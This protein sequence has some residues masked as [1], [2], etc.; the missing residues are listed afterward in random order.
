MFNRIEDNKKAGKDIQT[1][2]QVSYL[3]IYNEQ[4]KDL[5]SAGGK[6]L[7]IFSTKQGIVV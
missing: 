2:I 4:L 3:E 5:L 7:K 1:S 6:D